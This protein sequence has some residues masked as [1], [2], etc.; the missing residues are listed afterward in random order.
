MTIAGRL[1]IPLT[2]I[3]RGIWPVAETQP[4]VVIFD[5]LQLLTN[6]AVPPHERMLVPWFAPKF[7]PVIVTF[8][9]SAAG[10]GETPRI[11]G[12]AVKKISSLAA[13]P[14]VTTRGPEVAAAGTEVRMDVLLH[15]LMVA[16]TPLKVTVLLP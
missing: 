15:E 4:V 3:C 10:F 1:A 9:P 7:S 16:V 11:C 2:V 14:T 13:P 6:A 8:A 5:W 12:C